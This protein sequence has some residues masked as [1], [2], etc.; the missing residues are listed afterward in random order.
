MTV[1]DNTPKS[2]TENVGGDFNMK[3]RLT[4][5]G[6]L[7][8]LGVVVLPWL[9]GSY[10]ISSDTESTVSTAEKTSS[11]SIEDN[12]IQINSDDEIKVFV[13]KIKPVDSKGR[14]IHKAKKVQVVNKVKPTEST[15]SISAN[16]SVTPSVEKPV[17]NTA[18]VDKQKKKAELNAEVDSEVA[19]KNI[20]NESTVT[21]VNGNSAEVV[22]KPTVTKP[23]VNNPS[24]TKPINTKKKVEQGYIVS[25]GVYLKRDGANKV[26]ND[27]KKKGFK[28]SSS[29]SKS[30]KGLATRVFLG[31]FSTRAAAGKERSK[32]EQTVGEKGW[33]IRY[34]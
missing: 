26:I 23:L 29:Q 12:S 25:V 31:P 7:I 21:N 24:V 17:V 2:S 18:A 27:L 15:K 14:Q 6:L 32:L 22:T 28:P 16:K 19:K 3:H 5:A 11:E 13:S 10:S 34:P 30:S 9:L 33:I 1:S 8:S 20:N 4:G